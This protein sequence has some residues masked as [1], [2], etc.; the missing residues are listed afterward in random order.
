MVFIR[1]CQPK[2]FEEWQQWYFENA[3]K[4]LVST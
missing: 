1:K 4:N 2:T 3:T